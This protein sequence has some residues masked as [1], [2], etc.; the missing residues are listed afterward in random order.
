MRAHIEIPR[1]RIVPEDVDHIESAPATM[2][3]GQIAT[4]DVDGDDPVVA[5]VGES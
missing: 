1:D 2:P 4:I 3:L 5:H